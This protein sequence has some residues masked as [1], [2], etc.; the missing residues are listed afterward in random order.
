MAITSAISSGPYTGNG[1]QTAFPFSFSAMASTDVVVRVNG[2]VASSSSYTVAIASGG[3]SGTVTFGTAPA[4]GAVVLIEQ[5]P[6]FLQDSQFLNEA[7]YSLDSVNAT[8]RRQS[9][10]ANWLKREQEGL[11][12]RALLVPEGESAPSVASLSGQDG[13]V[14]AIID[15]EISPIPNDAAGAADSAAAAQSSAANAEAAQAAAELAQDGAE[16]AQA[17]AELA[18]DAAETAQAAAELAQEGA[19]TAQAA[20]ELAQEGAE[21]A[22]AAAEAAADLA[23][24]YGDMK[25]YR[26]WALLNAVTGTA[27]DMATVLTDS[28]THTDPVVGGTVSNSGIFAWV[29]SP[30]GWERIGNTSAA[31][32]AASAAEAATTL[33]MVS[34]FPGRSDWISVEI[35]ALGAIRSLGLYGTDPAKFYFVKYLFWKD[36]GT[37]F[38]LTISQ[39][40]DEIG[41]GAV[42]VAMYVLA[43]GG[44]AGSWN[45]VREIILAEEGGSGITGAAII[46]FSDT[47]AMAVNIAPSSSAS[48]ERRQIN[49]T[50]YQSSD[51]RTADINAIITASFANAPFAT[52][53]GKYRPFVDTFDKTSAGTTYPS[54]MLA[55]FVKN[56]WVY[57]ARKDHTYRLSYMRLSTAAACYIDLYDETD[58]RTAA[59]WLAPSI[60]GAFTSQPRFIKGDSGDLFL[61]SY[62]GEYFVLDLDWTQAVAVDGPLSTAARGGLHPD[63]IYDDAQLADFMSN[64]VFHEII[65]VG[66]SRSYTTLRAAVEALYST[67]TVCW[68]AHYNNQILIQLDP[69]TYE[70]TNLVLPDWVSIRGAGRDVTTIEVENSTHYALLQAHLDHKIMDL[71]VQSDTGDGGSWAGEY[72]I[73]SDDVG[74]SSWGGANQRRRIRQVY[75]RLKL[76][77]GAAQNTNLLGG[78]FSSGQHVITDDIICERLN[79]S[80]NAADL[81]AHNTAENGSYPGISAQTLPVLWEA[82]KVRASGTVGAGIQVVSLGSGSSGSMLTLDNCEMQRVSRVITTA[83]DH[84]WTISGVFDGAVSQATSADLPDTGFRRRMTNS[85]GSTLTAGRLVKR[86]GAAT[87]AYAGPGDRVMGWLP[88]AISNGGRGDV[89]VSRRIS[90]AFLSISGSGTEG[91]FGLAADGQISFAATPKVGS[92]YSGVAELWA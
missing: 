88:T 43:D 55:A 65:K 86:T 29:A 49:H 2:A 45:T 59:R 81:S 20:A 35:R 21:T 34:L 83:S 57:G 82:R 56:A 67:G 89:I 92:V 32:A 90:A 72:C 53:S 28:G 46:D 48:F 87:I 12:S 14:L 69:G 79:A 26:T 52:A 4:S 70:A 3:N 22:Q 62:T 51:A 33:A 85:T 71:T 7:A 23:G 13:K 19:E 50:A 39:A 6:D 78:G 41:T 75:R 66:P 18:Q 64:D 10:R 11:S 44:G 74:I 15:G 38:N 80:A 17:A 5:S 1:S 47:S 30:A 31:D 54:G 60:V 42:D 9:M 91:E 84:E 27:G 40:D 37:R 16:T 73:H 61:A 25:V 36:V 8:N 76:I 77:G 58:G 68:R 24:D 63:C